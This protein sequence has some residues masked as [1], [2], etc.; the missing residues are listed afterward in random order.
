MRLPAWIESSR[1]CGDGT[2]EGYFRLDLQF[3]RVGTAARKAVEVHS[4]GGVVSAQIVY[5][6]YASRRCVAK[7]S[8]GLTRGATVLGLARAVAGGDPPDLLLEAIGEDATANF[9]KYLL[10][11]TGQ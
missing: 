3:E 8:F 4:L 6:Y 11:V 1:A 5:R 2:P 9:A 7:R 10:L